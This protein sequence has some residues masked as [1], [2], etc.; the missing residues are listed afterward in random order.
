M[1]PKGSPGAFCV[2]ASFRQGK[3]LVLKDNGMFC[4][5]IAVVSAD[6]FAA[7]VDLISD[8]FALAGIA[9]LAGINCNGV[10]SFGHKILLC[11]CP[12]AVDAAIAAWQAVFVKKNNDSHTYF[13][14]LR[15]EE[16]RM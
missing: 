7:E 11:C 2:S 4:G 10:G 16:S 3:A 1:L 5:G 9:G 8:T 6:I 14:I 15:T 12:V 13:I